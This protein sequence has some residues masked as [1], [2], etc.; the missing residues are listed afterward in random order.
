M[1]ICGEDES[2]KT[3]EIVPSIS[4]PKLLSDKA[5]SSTLLVQ[6]WPNRDISMT[7]LSRI[8][9]GKIHLFLSHTLLSTYHSL[10][11]FSLLVRVCLSNHL[12]VPSRQGMGHFYLYF[13]KGSNRE[14]DKHPWTGQSCDWTPQTS[15]GPPLL[16]L[17]PHKGQISWEWQNHC[18]TLR[19]TAS[20]PSALKRSLRRVHQDAQPWFTTFWMVLQLHWGVKTETRWVSS[21]AWSHIL[22]IGI[23]CT[24]VYVKGITEHHPWFSVRR[25]LSTPNFP[26]QKQSRKERL[27]MVF[28]S[29]KLCCPEG[30]HL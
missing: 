16:N 27:A 3:M 11:W 7:I 28:W 21:K 12:W 23:Q 26:G 18:L 4:S 1:C 20:A 22:L 6:K 2:L 15:Q 19:A 14:A 10:S 30:D 5:S 9:P 24:S 17:A 13:S 25:G 8:L 29:M